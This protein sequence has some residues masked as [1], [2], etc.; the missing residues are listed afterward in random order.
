MEQPAQT[1]CLRL[2]GHLQGEV[3]FSHAVND[4]ALFRFTLAVIRRSGVFDLLPVTCAAQQGMEHWA[5]GAPLFLE[6]QLRAYRHVLAGGGCRVL[7]TAFAKH[8]LPAEQPESENSVLLTGQLVRRPV[9]RQTPAGREIADLLLS[10]P[11]AFGREDFLPVIAWGR[12]ARF[13]AVQEAGTRLF[14]T[15]R[16]QSRLYQKR[17]PDGTAAEKTAYEVSAMELRPLP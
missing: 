11:R 17:L 6:G 13:A 16:F 12:L 1:N 9:Y 4:T 7:L 10:V 8:I 3:T 14:I 5:D 15:G 2:S